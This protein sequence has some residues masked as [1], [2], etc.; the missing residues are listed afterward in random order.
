MHYE[1]RLPISP[2]SLTLSAVTKQ[3]IFSSIKEVVRNNPFIV[4]GSGRGAQ[5]V[6]R[7]LLTPEIRGS[8]PVVGKVYLLL[9]FWKDENEEKE[10]GSGRI[11]EKIS[12]IVWLC[13]WRDHLATLKSSVR[14]S[15]SI[16]D[17]VAANYGD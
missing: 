6:E 12:I 2:I 8:I 16:D 15:M 5:L 7:S 17:P 3:G 13:G 10:A 1:S 4:G 14:I 11:L 9:L